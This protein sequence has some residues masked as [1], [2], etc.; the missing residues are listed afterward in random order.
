MAATTSHMW[1]S[2]RH[3]S[4][5]RVQRK[6]KEDQSQGFQ[7]W[8][9]DCRFRICDLR[10]ASADAEPWLAEDFQL[11]NARGAIRHVPASLAV[12]PLQITEHSREGGDHES[13]ETEGVLYADE[14][15]EIPGGTQGSLS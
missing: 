4:A 2:G 10:S 14:V 11:T 6:N 8:I 3:K 1:P 7:F 13:Y 9:L 15:M 12:D 5:R